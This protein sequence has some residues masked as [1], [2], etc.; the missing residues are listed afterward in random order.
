VNRAERATAR[1][2]ARRRRRD[3]LVTAAADPDGTMLPNCYSVTVH[4]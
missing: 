2:G 3:V 4:G 1:V